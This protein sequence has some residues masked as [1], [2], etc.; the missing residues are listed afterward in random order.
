MTL[1]TF[2]WGAFWT[3]VALFIVSHVAFGWFYSDELIEGG[4]E[5]DGAPLLTP[6]GDYQLEEVTYESP[7]GDMPALYLPAG[8]ETWVIHVHGKGATPAEAEHLF[9]PIQQAGFPQLSI[10][11]RND[12]G[13]PADPSGYYQY[14]ATEWEDVAAAVD[15]AF[16]NGAENIVL[17]GFSTGASHVMSFMLNRS[18]DSVVGVLMDSPNVNMGETVSYRASQTDM[19]VLPMTVPPTLTATAKFITSMR[20]GVNWKAI[21]Y[22]ASADVSIRQPVLV[23]HGTAD[24]SVPISESLELAEARPDMVRLITVPDAGH[25]GSYDVAPEEY[26]AEVLAFL[27]QV[28]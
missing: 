1:R 4:F 6:D 7:L 12:D 28:G 25:V 24:D 23:H 2:L 18:L 26:V 8:G 16:E 3:L 5:I 11:Y 21:D 13:V 27:D 20:I 9:A 22:I 15:Y 17:S 10:A 19:P 14:G